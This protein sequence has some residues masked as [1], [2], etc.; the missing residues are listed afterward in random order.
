V[1]GPE[2]GTWTVDLH[3]DQPSC[4]RGFIAAQCGIEINHSDF[5]DLIAANDTAAAGMRLYFQGRLK[6]TGD[7]MLATKL[8]RLFGLE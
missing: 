5:M 8:Q 2:G 7:P 6:V 1:I 4:R 3:A